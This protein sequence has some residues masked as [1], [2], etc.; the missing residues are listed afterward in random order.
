MSDITCAVHVNCSECGKALKE[1]KSGCG[2]DHHCRGSIPDV[3][4]YANE[5]KK[6][7]CSMGRISFEGI[8][9]DERVESTVYRY[10]TR[11]KKEYWIGYSDE[12]P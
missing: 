4:I 8:P 3:V 1:T 5:T 2:W 7:G 6:N 12:S 10:N 9:V 11:S